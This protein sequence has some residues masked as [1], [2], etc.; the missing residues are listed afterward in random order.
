[1]ERAQIETLVA[2][3]R[4][5][6]KDAVEILRNYARGARG[7]RMD[8]PPDLHEF[9]W[10]WFIDGPPK[11]KSGTSPKDTVLKYE[12]IALLVK[13]VSQGLRFPGVRDSEHHGNPRGPHV[14]LP[15]GRRGTGARQR[16]VEVYG[17]TESDDDHPA[18]VRTNSPVEFPGS[19]S[20]LKG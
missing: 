7:A 9:V 20:H 4:D 12:T 13:I 14:G 5:G 11:T 8:V 19:T 2:F 17:P 15:V 3:A 18:V 1:M 6:D 10:E 16:W